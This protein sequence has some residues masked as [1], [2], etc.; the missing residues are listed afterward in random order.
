[1]ME[2]ITSIVSDTDIVAAVIKRQSKGYKDWPDER[3]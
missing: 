3:N 1:M 2:W